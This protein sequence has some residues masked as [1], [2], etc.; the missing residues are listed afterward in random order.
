MKHLLL[1]ILTFFC[2]IIS[3]LSMIPAF[4]AFNSITNDPEGWMGGVSME[5][6]LVWFALLFLGF[7]FLV[8]ETFLAILGI[9]FATKKRIGAFWL[10][11][12]PGSIGIILSVILLIIMIVYDI[13]WQNHLFVLLF[14]IIPSIFYFSYGNSIRK[15]FP[16]KLKVSQ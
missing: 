15:L 12:F 4:M 16:K 7:G 11:K 6:T 8:I 10:L 14:I 5:T 1:K 9:L 3:L 13:D 2:V